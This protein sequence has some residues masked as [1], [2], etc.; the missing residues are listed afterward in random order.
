MSEERLGERVKVA[1][2]ARQMTMAELAAECGLTKGFIS[3]L[4]SGASNP[5]L[6]TLRSIGVA[7]NVPVTEL[8]SSGARGSGEMVPTEMLRPT[9]LHEA[10]GLAREPGV[11]VISSG[12]DGNHSLV[13]VPHGS[14]LVHTVN[15][16]ETETHGTVIG[17]VLIGSVSLRQRDQELELARGAVASWDT[18]AGYTIEATGPSDATLVL[19]TPYGC[20]LPTY[21][22]NGRS[23][24]TEK[25][26]D[27]VSPVPARLNAVYDRARAIPVHL[28]IKG[29]NTGHTRTADGSLRLVAMRAQRLAER[30]GQ[31]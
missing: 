28:Q 21:Q 29:S 22:D 17:T 7:L 31:S 12:P 27:S 8:L 19:Y 10:H 25:P 23:T 30:R 13:V 16:E 9:I 14:R 11:S 20:P 6:N 5:S 4:E 26:V 24:R 1:R 3:Q 15:V 18:A 2:L